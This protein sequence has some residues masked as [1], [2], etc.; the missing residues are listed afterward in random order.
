M[1]APVSLTE[2]AATR[3]AAI[4]KD[5]PRRE[6]PLSYLEVGAGDGVLGAL[7]AAAGMGVAF[8]DIRDWRKPPAAGLHFTHADCCQ[9]LPYADSTFDIVASFNA[10]EHMLDPAKAF[11]ELVRVTRPGGII[12]LDFSPLY[13]SA[14]GLHA[15]TL[16]MP[17]PQLLFSNDFIMQKLEDLGISDFGEMRDELQ[18]LNGWTPQQY[19]SGLRHADVER[20]RW[21]WFIEEHYLNLVTSYPES[22]SGRGLSLEDIT[23]SYLYASFRKNPK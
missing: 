15:K 17:Y 2:R 9:G 20:F 11:A 18:S 6:E 4:L 10:F 5:V 8:C 14:N 3:I 13:C 1:Y 21:R 7:L 23:H 22:F 16:K 12:H 19:D